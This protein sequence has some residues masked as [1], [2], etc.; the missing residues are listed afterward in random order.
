MKKKICK[1][2]I[3]LGILFF[4]SCS[5][6]DKSG[7]T[8]K[9][10]EFIGD[11]PSIIAE[12][13]DAQQKLKEEEKKKGETVKNKDDL[14]KAMTELVKK[15][16]EIKQKAKGALKK[17][18]TELKGKLLPVVNNNPDIE[19]S[20]VKLSQ[21]NKA[22]IYFN[23]NITLRK[24]MD[25]GNSEWVKYQLQDKE[26]NV[27]EESKANIK[28]PYE[29]G[30]KDIKEG[31]YELVDIKLKLPNPEAFKLAKIVFIP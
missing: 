22:C 4:V 5:G 10:N 12:Y 28:L 19:V 25:L 8:S 7:S 11:V 18:E 21:I 23:G 2:V 30:R 1:S 31:N 20:D 9:T 29:F 6:S 15:D 17:A 16:E 13:N 24:N 26:G 27:I 14:I 3:G